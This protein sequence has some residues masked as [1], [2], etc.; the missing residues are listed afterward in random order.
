MHIKLNQKIVLI[1]EF[2]LCEQHLTLAFD[3]AAPD[4]L[5]TELQVF[6][7]LCDISSCKKYASIRGYVRIQGHGFTDEDFKRYRNASHATLQLQLQD[8]SDLKIARKSIKTEEKL[9]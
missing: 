5:L 7:K 9:Q 6:Q 3:E 2:A 8:Y 1:A 4:V